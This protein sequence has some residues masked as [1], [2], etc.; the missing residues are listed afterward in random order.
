MNKKL[1]RWAFVFVWF[2]CLPLGLTVFTISMFSSD[3]YSI[4]Q[5][6]G[7]EVVRFVSEQK[8]PA[9]IVFFTI[10]EAIIYSLR[11]S[12]P[13]ADVV[14]IAGRP[15]LPKSSRRDYE[16]AGQLL[17]EVNLVLKK[18]KEAIEKRLSE[19]RR[20]ELDAAMQ[21]LANAM[22]AKTFSVADF[23]AA[24]DRA[25][26]MAGRHLST[27]QRGEVREYTESII[28]AVGVALLLR[29][30]VV[31]AFKIPSGSMLPTLQISDHIFVNKFTYGPTIPFSNQRLLSSLPPA[32]GDV[33]VFEFPDENKLNPREN[34]I[35]RAIALPGD[36]L[37]TRGGHPIINGW[38]VP[39]CRVGTYVVD[40]SSGYPQ[41]GEL[42]VEYLGDY[43]Y[44]TLY[45][46][47]NPEEADRR[48]GPY[49]VA[50]DEF[51]VLG[52]NRNSS[53]DSRRWRNGKG[54][55]VPYPNVK[56]RA[57]FVWLSFNDKGSDLWGVTW[58]RLFTSVMGK[59]RL[60]KEAPAALT[61]EIERCLAERPT[62]TT[63]PAPSAAQ[64]Q[65]RSSAP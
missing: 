21:A 10:F 45:E 61:K 40:E 47:F 38:E 33:V 26:E 20:Q 30:F 27:W 3:G 65:A 46:H 14:G 32:R 22:D 57:L 59:P 17:D 29:A 8:V 43:S 62:N 13:L 16:Q 55:G 53:S 1:S 48:E 11:Y 52:D 9:L 24:Y 2:L 35:K 28:I 64:L 60:P 44:L 58:D 63:P 19:E 54:A 5:G 49:H 50:K 18:N 37:E 23:E 51:W 39:S 41:S 7:G 25:G 15:G 4:P 36:I 12:L 34:F 6:I 56:G 42:F 31:E